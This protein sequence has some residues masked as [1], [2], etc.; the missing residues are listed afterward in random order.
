MRIA[1][2]EGLRTAGN[3][4]IHSWRVDWSAVIGLRCY[5]MHWRKYLQSGIAKTLTLGIA[6]FILGIFWQAAYYY[7]QRLHYPPGWILE[8]PPYM[9]AKVLTLLGAFVSIG[10][11]C[12]WAGRSIY[13]KISN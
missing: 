9:P 11:L 3:A 7:R 12:Y 6:G 10:S 13:R 8:F 2:L 1:L 5:P 4:R